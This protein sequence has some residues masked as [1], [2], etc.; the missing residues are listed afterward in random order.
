MSWWTKI[1]DQK[2]VRLNVGGL[3]LMI[4]DDKMLAEGC[5]SNQTSVVSIIDCW[6]QNAG[7]R[8]RLRINVG[9]SPII[10]CGV[11]GVGPASRSLRPAADFIPVWATVHNQID[12]MMFLMFY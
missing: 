5:V 4:A 11:G 2:G 12:S 8:M 7:R 9:S 1:P 6:P 3:Q 10:R